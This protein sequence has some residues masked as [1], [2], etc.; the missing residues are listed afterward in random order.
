[1]IPPLIR[2]RRKVQ[3]YVRDQQELEEIRRLG[4][5]ETALLDNRQSVHMTMRQSFK[6]KFVKGKGAPLSREE[7]LVAGHNTKTSYN[8][9]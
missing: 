9:K 2:Y 7:Q 8:N 6:K 4:P 3:K 1:M 5:S